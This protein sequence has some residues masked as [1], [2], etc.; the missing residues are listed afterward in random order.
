MIISEIYDLLA[1]ASRPGAP[2]P[3]LLPW[4]AARI[5]LPKLSAPARAA[6]AVGLLAPQAGGWPVVADGVAEVV[7]RRSLTTDPLLEVLDAL[8]PIAAHLTRARAERVNWNEAR[9]DSRGYALIGKTAEPDVSEIADRPLWTEVLAAAEVTSLPALADLRSLA[10]LVVS[11]SAGLPGALTDEETVYLLPFLPVGIAER[12]AVIRAVTSATDRGR[13]WYAT[14]L[15]ARAAPYLNESARARISEIAAEMPPVWSAHIL[16]LLARPEPRWASDAEESEA[17]HPA[18]APLNARAATVDPADLAETTAAAIERI[19]SLHGIVTRWQP[20]DDD[21]LPAAVTR[22][23]YQIPD[24]RQRVLLR[25]PEPPRFV[26]IYVATA[27]DGQ[28]VRTVPLELNTDYEVRCNIGP[29]DYRNLLDRLSARLPDQLLPPGPVDLQ[30]VLFVNGDTT[31]T[32]LITVPAEGPSNWVRLP[33]PAQAQP[34]VLG[35]ELVL[36]YQNVAMVAVYSLTLPVGCTDEGPRVSLS[37]QL[38]GSLTDLDKIADRTLSII[39][40]GNGRALYINGLTSGVQACHYDPGDIRKLAF[41]ARNSLY[42]AHFRKVPEGEQSRYVIGRDRSH[43]KRSPSLVA[44]LRELARNGRALYDYLFNDGT[45]RSLLRDEADRLGR[46]PI[47]QMA[48]SGSEI[49]PIPWA[50]V[51]DLPLGGHPEEYVQCRSIADLVSQG[52]HS[53][54]SA[55]CPYEYEHRDGPGWKLDQLCPWGFWGL[56]TII[57]HPPSVRQRDLEARIDCSASV[58]RILMGYDTKLEADL[59]AE[60]LR[61]LRREYGPAL[62][63][64]QIVQR[65]KFKDALK[66][67]D[68]DVVYLYCHVSDDRKSPHVRIP[69]IELGAEYVTSDDIKAWTGQGDYRTAHHPLVIINGCRTVELGP[70][71]LFNFVDAFVN[72]NQAS[73]VIGTEITIEQGLGA[74]AMELFLSALREY[75]VGQ[76]LWRVRWTMFRHGNLMGLGY[77]P[78]CLAG[79]KLIPPAEE[80]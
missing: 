9:P 34:A 73:G 63:D 8:P 77:T 5:G 2:E 68:M 78:Y 76:S 17:S 6:A 62:I 50:I 27:S 15:V 53:E 58:P 40:P 66:R 54:P 29:L 72:N 18:I 79:L 7:A 48:S 35:A 26:N 46:P 33:L 37:H 59:I 39:D 52:T 21:W 57:E 67:H 69:A 32:G 4:L 49:L 14:A 45:L 28:P 43:Q 11:E 36:Y 60:H 1:D 56:S 70:G 51:Y 10:T 23:A 20:D 55:R 44:D 31:A 13:Y 80:S 47:L 42:D 64:P 61:Q 12:G 41:A 19:T 75:T 22:Q 16:G 74:W 65:L 30:A 71:S 3:T 38:S 24:S 25:P